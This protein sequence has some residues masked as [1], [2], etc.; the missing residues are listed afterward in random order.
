MLPTEADWK[1]LE[2]EHPR[3]LVESLRRQIEQGGLV[4]VTAELL[5]SGVQTTSEDAL[6]LLEE[7]A[8]REWLREERRSACRGCRE[9]L[10]PE[11]AAGEV[12]PQCG[13]AFQDHGGIL[14]ERAFVLR[15]APNRDVH[16]VLALHGMNTSGA[17]QEDLNW[18]VSRSYGR[19]VPVA[20]YKYG[21]IRPGAIL[22]WRQRQLVR[23]LVRRIG[24]LT[25]QSADAG[26]GKKPDVI[27]HSFGTWLLGHA[28]RENR[29]LQVGRVILTGSILR[30]DFPWQELIDTQQV[31][32]VLDHYGTRDIWA[33]VAH[34]LIPDTGPSGR[35]GFDGQGVVN[36]PAEGFSHSQFFAVGPE[37]NELEEAFR[38]VWQ[39]FLTEPL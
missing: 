6:R 35:R 18:L 13:Q 30:P 32:A 3:E 4:D 36:V 10:S 11:D 27:A 37:K 25:G 19:M 39:P 24:D 31:E 1:R 26:F 8:A 34:Y 16:W 21:I 2:H 9:P 22:K 14:E 15:R 7:F 38:T 17:W 28:L 29:N 12:C 20:I 23:G 33:G 5:A